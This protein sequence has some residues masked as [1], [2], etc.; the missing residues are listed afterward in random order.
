MLGAGIG[1][2]RIINPTQL[3]SS[4]SLCLSL[5]LFID[6]ID[7]VF[8]NNGSTICLPFS[9]PKRISVNIPTRSPRRLVNQPPNWVP[10]YGPCNQ[11]GGGHM[12]PTW[13]LLRKP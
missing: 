2:F 6:L 7:S 9:F 12:V 11:R 3:L 8:M 10:T 1:S 5:L 4:L 13:L